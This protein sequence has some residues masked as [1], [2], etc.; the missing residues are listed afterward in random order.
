[1]GHR[2]FFLAMSH[3]RIGTDSDRASKHFVGRRI[4]NPLQDRIKAIGGCLEYDHN[5][6]SINR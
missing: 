6:L 3:P 1:M 5:P 2:G 4:A